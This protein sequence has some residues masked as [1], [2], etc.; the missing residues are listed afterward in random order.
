MLS[1]G[2]QRTAAVMY[3]SFNFMPSSRS[4]AV[5][6]LA[7]PV[8][9][10]TGYMKLPEAS[11]VNGRPVRFE[12]WAPGASPMTSTRACGSPKPGTG[13]PQYSQLRYARRFTRATSWR[14]S[15]SLGQRVQVTTSRL[16]T[17]SQFTRSL[18][19]RCE[20][21]FWECFGNPAQMSPYH[22]LTL[23]SLSLYTQDER[24]VNKDWSLC[25]RTLG[26]GRI[27]PGK[28]KGLT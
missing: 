5:G 4:M 17:V 6:W 21:R 23:L 14:Y 16:R 19:H 8:S 9:Y 18:H 7:N 13:F 26:S 28:P 2:A 10:S 3:R 20:F 15:T 24:R 27:L 11:P 12:P 22:R 25:S 1:G